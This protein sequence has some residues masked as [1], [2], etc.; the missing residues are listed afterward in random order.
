MDWQRV[1]LTHGQTDKWQHT[2]T[3]LF[4]WSMT[5]YNV[6]TQHFQK[7][8][9]K[10]F[11]VVR[12]IENVEWMEWWTNWQVCSYRRTDSI[13]HNTSLLVS[14]IVATNCDLWSGWS[15][16][17][18]TFSSV[19]LTFLP[20]LRIIPIHLYEKLCIF[21]ESFVQ[22]S[23]YRHRH[24]STREVLISLH[25]LNIFNFFKCSYWNALKNYLWLCP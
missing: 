4:L 13:Y 17:F 15:S 23:T 8:W 12:V 20:Y 7:K 3:F 18:R 11:E 24:L 9:F 16:K 19:Y 21:L 14:S 22:N 10:S 6:T 25:M 5:W 2:I 1:K